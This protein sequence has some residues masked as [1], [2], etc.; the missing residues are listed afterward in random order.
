MPVYGK[1]VDRKRSRQQ[2]IEIDLVCD[3]VLNESPGGNKALE[4]PE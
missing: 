2:K 3:E 1:G 4:C